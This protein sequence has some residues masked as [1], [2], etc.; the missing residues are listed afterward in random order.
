M[1]RLREVTCE[2]APG[3]GARP[4]LEWVTG[5][6]G[7]DARRD[8]GSGGAAGLAA[9]LVLEGCSELG[10]QRQSRVAPK[11]VGAEA[12]RATSQRC[13]RRCRAPCPHAAGDPPGPGRDRPRRHMCRTM[14]SLDPITSCH[15]PTGAC[16][17]YP[18][19]V[20]AGIL[21]RRK[22]VVERGPET[23]VVQHG[24]D[25]EQLGVVRDPFQ[26]TEARGPEVR[27]L[28]VIDQSRGAVAH[29]DLTRGL[30]RWARRGKQ[31][32]GV[33]ARSVRA[34][35]TQR[36]GR[37]P[38]RSPAAPYHRA[39]ATVAEHDSIPTGR[40]RRTAE[41]GGLVGVQTRTRRWAP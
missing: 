40:L 4:L 16:A 29:D 9:R 15:R 37:P 19:H 3:A 34:P 31:A 1:D 8:G 23:E 27:A 13:G 5:Q 2:P 32:G 41:I 33:H 26:P 25:V 35:T 36:D 14:I 22:V 11:H 6:P 18:A 28:A 38:G 21:E 20:A 12:P 10:N 30:G 17:E 24:G 39:R 7:A